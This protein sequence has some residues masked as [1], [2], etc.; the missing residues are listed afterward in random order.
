MKLNIKHFIILLSIAALQACTGSNSTEVKEPLSTSDS[1]DIDRATIYEVNVRHYSE[2]GD[3]D[4]FIP[5]LDRL[6]DLGVDILWF[7]PI[8]PIGAVNRKAEGDLFVQDIQ[9]SSLRAKYLGS[10]YSIS[11]YRAVNP[12][13]G[14]VDDFKKLVSVCHDKG[15]KV[16]IDWVG[17]H[18]AWDHSWITEHPEWY[19]KKDGKITDPLNDQGESIG[20]TDVAD[21]NYDEQGLWEAMTADMIFWVEEC[22]IDGFRCDVAFE[23]PAEFWNYATSRLNNIK[24]MIMLA[25]AEAHNMDLYDSAFQF[26]YGWS[27][28]HQMNELAKGNIL[29]EDFVAEYY[30]LDSIF[31]GKVDPMQFI[32]NHDE[33]SWNGT[34]FE[35]MGNRWNQMAVVSY[36]IHGLPLLYTGQEVGLSHRLKFFEKDLVNWSVSADSMSKYTEFY[37]E[38]NN[39]KAEGL[40]D[41]DQEVVL[42][43]NFDVLMI[44]RPS[45]ITYVNFG[46][47]KATVDTKYEIA[48]SA[49]YVD[50]DLNAGGFVVLKKDKK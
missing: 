14:S 34:V 5:H 12:D 36:A 3:F 48:L 43:N 49:N 37:T 28:H 22:D 13:Y 29:C 15:F 18:T 30:R 8:H 32:T 33:N 46:S 24:P 4:G 11:D 50:G 39:L 10:P 23:V 31:A 17:N 6:K 1:F 38:L 41:L 27:M 16:L 25:E 42:D 26:H 20:W 47:E 45:S 9:D 40:F 19:T 44:T 7:M 35:R 2:K 21:L